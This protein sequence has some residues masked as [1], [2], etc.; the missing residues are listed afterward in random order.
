MIILDTNV[1]SALMRQVPD[2]SVVA[3][4]D[5]QPRTSIWTTSVTILEV[6]FGLQIMAGGKR[7][8][9]LVQ[10]FEIVLDTIGHR[11]APF[12]MAAAQQAGDVMA[13]RHK[14]GR[15]GELRDTMIAGIVLAQHAT[16]ATRNTIH[17]DDVLVP[18]VDPWTA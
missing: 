7:R 8:S 4:L 16:L 2:K 18:L 9:A 10:A 17:F 6:R 11:V 5:R 13:S 3:W 14:T 15:P 12:D 1:L